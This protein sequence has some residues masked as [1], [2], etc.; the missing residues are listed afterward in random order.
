[1]KWAESILQEWQAEIQ[2][3]RSGKWQ[4]HIMV[5]D[6]EQNILD[7]FQAVLES[8][9]CHVD[10]ARDGPE[11]LSK[12]RAKIG[13]RCP[14]YDL[15]FLDLRMPKMTGDEVLK[16]IRAMCPRIPV[17]IVTAFPDSEMLMRAADIGYFGLIVKP[18]EVSQLQTIL[19]IHKLD[20][21]AIEAAATNEQ[22]RIFE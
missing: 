6:D 7:S 8:C 19:N 22:Q 18:F 15:I 1:M 11:G 4:P 17:V 20:V 13:L 9:G 2:Q 10:A 16:E 12:M 21:T 5:I 14:P 3:R